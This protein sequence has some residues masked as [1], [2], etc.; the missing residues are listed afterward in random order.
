MGGNLAILISKHCGRE[1]VA[2]TWIDSKSRL[3][4]FIQLLRATEIGSLVRTSDPPRRCEH[5]V[6]KQQAGIHR[7]KAHLLGC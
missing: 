6:S 4:D 1:V 2:I 3:V 5:F 7:G